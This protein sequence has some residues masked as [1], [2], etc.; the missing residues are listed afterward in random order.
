M[1]AILGD[2]E[3]QT[4]CVKITVMSTEDM[5]MIIRNHVWF[6]GK[7]FRADNYTEISSDTLC[8]VYYH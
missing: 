3:K 7:Y 2:K 5:D 8:A 6:G 4:A 1:K